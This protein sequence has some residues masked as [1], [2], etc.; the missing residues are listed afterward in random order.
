MTPTVL[1]VWIRRFFIKSPLF[2]ILCLVLLLAGCATQSSPPTL[3]QET[4]EDA[5]ELQTLGYTIQVGAFANID[6][7]NRLSEKLIAQGLDAFFY[8]EHDLYKV[9]FGNFLH[10]S[11]AE[12]A[13]R[14]LSK[15][16]FIP[17]YYIVPPESYAV[18]K[19]HKSDLLRGKLIDTAE[20]FLG[21]PYKWG[22]T[23]AEDGFDCSGLSMVVYKLNGMNLPRTSLM[24]FQS[25]R[26]VAKQ[27][28]KAGDLVFFCTKKEGMVSHVGIYLGDDLFIHAPRR[29]KNI[30]ISNLNSNYFSTRYMGARTYMF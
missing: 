27:E 11:D 18:S 3:P 28:M 10:F 7:A 24:Q 1:T 26:P 4:V 22:G 19:Y 8:V 20:D 25:G 9:R 5:G 17:E 15:E 2:P 23:S 16:S 30:T 29:G 14:H 13:A 6:N 21:I 12:T